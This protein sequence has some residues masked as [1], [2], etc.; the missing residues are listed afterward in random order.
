MN[1]SE[2]RIALKMALEAGAP[3]AWAEGKTIE[4]S[5]NAKGK[6]E[7]YKGESPAWGNPTIKWRVPKPLREGW[8]V[9]PKDNI[10]FG[11]KSKE[12]AFVYRKGLGGSAS[13]Y[14]IVFVREVKDECK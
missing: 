4:V 7:E 10:C 11:H 6:W 1:A 9:V 8:I 13:D 12:A 5:V 2:E 14:E 3:Q